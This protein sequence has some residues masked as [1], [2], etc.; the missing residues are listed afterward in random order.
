M[1]RLERV[2]AMAA[3]L[4]LLTGCGTT[5][6]QTTT[7][8]ALENEAAEFGENLAALLNSGKSKKLFD[9]WTGSDDLD[10]EPLADAVM[11]GAKAKGIKWEYKSGD[12]S[13]Q[14]GS[15]TLKWTT[16]KRHSS[17]EYKVKKVDGEWRLEDN[18][19]IQA[20][21][22]S[23]FSVD[24]TDAPVVEALEGGLGPC[25][26]YDNGGTSKEG[27]ILLLVPGEHTVSVD[28]LKN[29]VK[30]PYKAMAYPAYSVEIDF[31]LKPGAR[32]DG[33]NLVP[34]KP[35]LASGYADAVKAAFL[36]DDSSSCESAQC[37][38]GETQDQRDNL[39]DGITVTPTDDIMHPIIG[40]TYQH[41]KDDG[42]YQRDASKLD[43]DLTIN[44]K[45]IFANV[46]DNESTGLGS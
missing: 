7:Q 38:N 31:S 46:Y 9:L 22:C 10:T 20:A 21:I 36:E 28:A 24:G 5:S 11:P 3:A 14:E 34:D 17:R 1:K 41:W 15:V 43:W 26:D 45:G 23:P 16:T 35:V 40:G 12:F 37:I 25:H 39:F 19:L 29:I 42:Y 2:I 13:S 4:L 44:E 33:T 18:P 6:A 32:E 8:S 27:Q 30:Q